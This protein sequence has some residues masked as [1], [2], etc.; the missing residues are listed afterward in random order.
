MTELKKQQLLDK[1]QE[2]LTHAQGGIFT[3]IGRERLLGIAR[4]YGGNESRTLSVF[5]SRTTTYVENALVDLDLF[6]QTAEKEKVDKVI[7]ADSLRPIIQDLFWAGEFRDKNRA[8]IAQLFIQMGFQ[9]LE[10]SLLHSLSQVHLR[11]ISE[12]VDLSRILSMDIARG[13]Q[14]D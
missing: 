11:S 9:Y 7:S 10:S 12:A 1:Y 4:K 14:G 5:W 6:I 3:K 2:H 13:V 8:E